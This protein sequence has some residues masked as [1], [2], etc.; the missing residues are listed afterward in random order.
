MNDNRLFRLQHI[1]RFHLG[2]ADGD[3]VNDL[4]PDI[5]VNARICQIVDLP[6]KRRYLRIFGTI[7]LYRDNIVVPVKDFGQ[8][9]FERRIA[10][11]M[12]HDLYAVNEDLCIGHCAVKNQADFL[13]GKLFAPTQG[14]LIGKAPLI[15][16]FVE[17]VE[18]Q[19]N[20][21]MRQ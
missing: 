18:R 10:V 20:G 15:A 5:P 12:T 11:A 9:H 8:R 6:A 3:R 19:V 17:I 13:T 21:V 7:D 4:E 16:G 1:H 14:L 2:V